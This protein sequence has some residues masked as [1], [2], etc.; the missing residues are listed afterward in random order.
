MDYN[1]EKQSFTPQTPK[2]ISSSLPAAKPAN[3]EK[4]TRRSSPPKRP[5]RTPTPKLPVN[6]ETEIQNARLRLKPAAARHIPPPLPHASTPSKVTEATK[7]QLP[8]SPQSSRA[9]FSLAKESPSSQNRS[10]KSESESDFSKFSSAA[11]SSRPSSN[12]LSVNTPS[13][14]SSR[15]SSAESASPSSSVDSPSSDSNVT[16]H[17]KRES[18][19]KA[20]SV[21][22]TSDD[23]SVKTELSQIRERILSIGVLSSTL[24][25]RAQAQVRHENTSSLPERYRYKIPSNLRT[26]NAKEYVPSNFLKGCDTLQENWWD[27]SNPYTVEAWKE[28]Y[29]RMCVVEETLQGADTDLHRENFTALFNNQAFQNTLKRGIRLFGELHDHFHDENA[30]VIEQRLSSALSR[31][32]TIAPTDPKEEASRTH[33][34]LSNVD[35]LSV[36][37]FVVNEILHGPLQTSRNPSLLKQAAIEIRNSKELLLPTSY[38]LLNDKQKKEMFRIKHLGKELTPFLGNELPSIY[39]KEGIEKWKIFYAKIHVLELANASALTHLNDSFLKDVLRQARDLFESLPSSEAQSVAKTFDNV[40]NKI[41]PNEQKRAVVERSSNSLEVKEERRDVS[42]EE[43]PPMP[44]LKESFALRSI[45]HYADKETQLLG[46][47]LQIPRSL[48][49]SKEPLRDAAILLAQ[50]STELPEIEAKAYMEVKKELTEL[51]QSL[52]RGTFNLDNPQHVALLQNFY[53]KMCMVNVEFDPTK[54]K[55]LFGLK[56][57]LPTL[58]KAISFFDQIAHQDENARQIAQMFKNISDRHY[59]SLLID[60]YN[61]MAENPSPNTS[62]LDEI[63]SKIYNQVVTSG[64]DTIDRNF[65]TLN[66]LLSEEITI[67]TIKEIKHLMKENNDL[68]NSRIEFFRKNNQLSSMGY[69]A[70]IQSIMQKRVSA[71]IGQH[72]EK[73]FNQVIDSELVI[74][75]K[76]EIDQI[77]QNP[78]YRITF[79][80][81]DFEELTNIKEEIKELVQTFAIRDGKMQKVYNAYTSLHMLLDKTGM[82]KSASSG[83]ITE[84]STYCRTQQT[85]TLQ[86]LDAYKQNHVR[87]PEKVK[88]LET[89]FQHLNKLFNAFGDLNSNDVSSNNLQQ[90]ADALGS[91]I[92]ENIEQIC[93]FL[94]FKVAEE[95]D[96]VSRVGNNTAYLQDQAR[97]GEGS[98]ATDTVKYT[99]QALS[100]IKMLLDEVNSTIDKT[101]GQTVGFKNPLEDVGLLLE[102]HLKHTV[103]EIATKAKTEEAAGGKAPKPSRVANADKTVKTE[104][105]DNGSVKPWNS[106]KATLHEGVS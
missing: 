101:E 50:G 28:F 42:I 33:K 32:M 76:R 59:Y 93:D 90:R 45:T 31:W 6:T 74:S 15:F 8:P 65:I 14:N 35:E 40:L 3:T 84:L 12:F 99:L 7:T 24:D 37:D 66:R 82:K 88:D 73:F 16:D 30:Q 61:K 36:V 98:S 18:I 80:K 27:L 51:S 64:L 71:L 67:H 87:E 10:S 21:W 78:D 68:L 86:A 105:L 55:E 34:A 29:A 72:L 23:A 53:A 94:K 46:S 79:S 43:A 54:L 69:I 49:K 103:P 63:K 9:S 60:A 26:L 39:T 100:R 25:R 75:L 20:S 4:T 41:S 56:D 11:S 17:V 57:F 47:S 83:I 62:E 85:L 104:F 2:D 44:T 38:T 58:Q 97:V 89:C 102:A 106:F 13:S 96:F 48:F 92:S 1:L 52:G 19:S 5:P 22:A 81:E 77:K 70:T 95:R 91:I